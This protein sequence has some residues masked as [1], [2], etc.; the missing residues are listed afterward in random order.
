MSKVIQLFIITAIEA[1]TFQEHK[2]DSNAASIIF[3][4]DYCIH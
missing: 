3:I 4:I 2:Y 1:I